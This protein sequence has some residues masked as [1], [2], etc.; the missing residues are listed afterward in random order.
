MARFRRGRKWV[1]R[2]VAVD[3]RNHCWSVVSNNGIVV[4][5]VEVQGSAFIAY[6]IS[7]A[8]SDWWIKL[9]LFW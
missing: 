4:G 1:E 3:K 8:R 6:N 7:W 5:T 2:R 9:S